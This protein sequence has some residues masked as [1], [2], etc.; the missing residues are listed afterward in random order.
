MNNKLQKAFTTLVPFVVIGVVIAVFIALLCLFFYV[1]IWGLIIGGILWAA[2]MLKLY[3]FPSKEASKDH[4]RVIEHDD[5][6]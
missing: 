5:K 3:F 4:G 1:A 6:K 2:S